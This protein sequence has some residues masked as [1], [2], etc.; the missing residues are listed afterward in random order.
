MKFIYIPLGCLFTLSAGAASPELDTAIQNV[1]TV[2]GN[3]SNDFAHIK[4]M[5]GVNTAVTGVGTAVGVGATAVGIAKSSLDKDI[6]AL[7]ENLRKIEVVDKEALTNEMRQYAESLKAVQ[8]IAPTAISEAEKQSVKMGN[9]RTGLLATN[10]ATNIAGAVIAGTN[11]VKKDLKSQIDACLASVKVLSNVYMQARISQT[12]PETEIQYAENIVRACD[13][14]ATVDIDSINNKSTGATVSSGI[15]AGVGLVG[16]IVSASANSSDVRKGDETREKNLNTAANVMAGGATVASGVAT[17]FNA[18]QISAAKRAIAV[19][20][21]CEGGTIMKRTVG[22]LLGA[23]LLCNGAFADEQSPQQI[24][25]ETKVLWYGGLVPRNFT[26][27]VIQL[28]SPSEMYDADINKFDVLDA[29]ESCLSYQQQ[30][31]EDISKYGSQYWSIK[32]IIK[33]CMET[34]TKSDSSEKC[35][36]LVIKSIDEHNQMVAKAEKQSAEVSEIN[37]DEKI[38]WDAGAVAEAAHYV[39]DVYPSFS[40][41]ADIETTEFPV[42]LYIRMH[43]RIKPNPMKTINELK[44]LCLELAQILPDEDWEQLESTADTACQNFIKQAIYL[45]NSKIGIIKE[46]QQRELSSNASDSLEL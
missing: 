12:A 7:Q 43:E 13:E 39:F 37:P 5:A 11:K 2:C 34:Y 44:Q 15:G 42:P 24:D 27:Y 41:L 46:Q 23:L 35:V 32:D 10:T 45:H 21:K 22:I 40:A 28:N 9:W 17:I 3:I 30:S 38:L 16:T 19:A 8:T 31:A 6:S 1:R 20:E 14:W 29:F 36:S 33:C 25:M 4:T 26:K 18:T